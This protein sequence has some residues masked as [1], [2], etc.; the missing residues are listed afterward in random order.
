MKQT[1]HKITVTNKLT[2]KIVHEEE[3][4]K[5]YDSNIK[6]CHIRTNLEDVYPK[7]KFTI[8]LKSI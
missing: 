5:M 3:T 7:E 4:G 6:A 8:D 1:N 2:D